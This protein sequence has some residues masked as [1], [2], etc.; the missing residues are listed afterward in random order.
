[1]PA[2]ASP[3]SWRTSARPSASSE[4]LRALAEGRLIVASH[5]PGKLAEIAEL[6][7]PLGIGAVGAAELGLPEPA[8]TGTSFADNA[9]LKARAAAKA[10]GAPA[11]ADDSGLM[12]RALGGAPGVATARWAG[13]ER[14]YARAFARIERELACT[15]DRRARFVATLALAWPDGAA[16]LFEGTCEGTLVFPPRGA[17]GFGYDPVFEPEG[18]RRTFAEMEPMEKRRYNHRARA[19]ARLAAALREAG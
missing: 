8:E 12:I 6:L 10:A 16:E 13:P 5:N 11:L 17:S 1:M 19:F 14:D 7:A 2:R 18:M 15:A 3:G 9:L 4:P